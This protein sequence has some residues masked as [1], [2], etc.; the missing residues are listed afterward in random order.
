MRYLASRV[1]LAIL[2]CFVLANSGF[3]HVGLRVNE[4]GVRFRLIKMHRYLPV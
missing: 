1:G 2:F 4:A 3:A